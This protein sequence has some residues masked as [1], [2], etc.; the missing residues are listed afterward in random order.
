MKTLSADIL[1][2]GV[3]FRYPNSTE[4]AVLAEID[5]E[6]AQGSTC[7]ILG[8][9]GCGKT[10]LLRLICD[11]LQPSAGELYIAPERLAGGYAVI[12]QTAPLLPWRT[13]LQNIT[14]G[15]ELRGEV[16]RAQLDYVDD[17][18][19]EYKLN[20]AENKKPGEISGG[21]R[22]RV[23]AL[24]AL[25]CRPMLLFCDEPF[26]AIDFVTRLALTTKFKK[27]CKLSGCTTVFITHN[28][29]EAIFLGDSIQVL[30]GR[31]A[32]IVASYTPRLSVHPEDAVLCRESPEFE[33]L[34]RQIWGKL[35][36]PE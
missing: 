19:Y 21:M 22:Q 32:R 29:E 6:I 18:I 36:E 13:V 5:L 20:G 12:A 9:S 10:T 15:L 27:L 26:S 1:L 2:K 14:I 31:P 3:G 4:P 33:E 34:F 17:L 25:A 16:R 11:E 8:P 24:R 23:A 30:G 35:D 28:I 7:C